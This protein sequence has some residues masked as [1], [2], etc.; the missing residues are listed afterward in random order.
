MA[1]PARKR[2]RGGRGSGFRRAAFV[3]LQLLFQYDLVKYDM[4]REEPLR[5]PR[6]FCRRVDKGR[7]A[8][9]AAAARLEPPQ[10]LRLVPRGDGPP[11]VKG[12]RRQPVF[13]LRRKQKPDGEEAAEERVCRG[14]RLLQHG[15]PDGRRPAGL[16]LLPGPGGRHLQV[17]SL[18]P[19]IQHRGGGG[20]GVGMTPPPLSGGRGRT[21]P[22]PRWPKP[23]AWWTS[24]RR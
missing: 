24:S 14:R 16:H 23:W 11:A 6:G 12:Q 9:A 7:R 8:A 20:G 18:R 10:H 5:D 21:W 15:R 4:A 17:R 1:T 2:E 3:C 13:R 19:L 22:P